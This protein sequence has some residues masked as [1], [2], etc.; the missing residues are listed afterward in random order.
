VTDQELKEEAHSDVAVAIAEKF[1][2]QPRDMPWEDRCDELATAAIQA[3]QIF[4]QL[5][6]GRGVKRGVNAQRGASRVG[7]CQSLSGAI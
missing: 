3:L 4:F 7:C 5:H 1:L 6:R 2:C